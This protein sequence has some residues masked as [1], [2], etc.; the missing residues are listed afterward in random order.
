ML[1]KYLMI[2]LVSMV[3]LIELRG[4]VP[5]AVGMNLPLLP[6]YII[7]ILGNM[8]PVPIIF[9]FARKVLE[10]GADKPVIGKFFTFCLEKG[11]KGRTKAAG[12]SGQRPVRGAVV[13]RGYS[14]SRNR[15]VDRNTG[16]KFVRHG[17]QV[18]CHCSN[19]RCGSGRRDHGI[20]QHGSIR[21]TGDYFLKNWRCCNYGE[22]GRNLY[23]LC[24]SI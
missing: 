12:K 8:L 17:F 13:V 5:I 2:F 1:K 15:C 11:H 18:Q 19:V 22:Y 9:F 21:R 6:S 3:P 20:A 24:K 16:S 10:W 4:A 7:C 14:P 23:R